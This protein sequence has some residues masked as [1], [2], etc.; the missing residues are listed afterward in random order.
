MQRVETSLRLLQFCLAL[1]PV[2]TALVL[3]MLVLLVLVRLVIAYGVFACARNT[4]R[5]ARLPL[6]S[7]ARVC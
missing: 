4:G 3:L 1:E 7:F 5:K 2:V 6:F